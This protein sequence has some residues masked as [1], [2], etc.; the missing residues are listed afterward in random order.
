MGLRRNLTPDEA[1][2]RAAQRRYHRAHRLYWYSKSGRARFQTIP[3][4]ADCGDHDPAI[5]ITKGKG[6]HASTRCGNCWQR[7][8]Y[9][10]AEQVRAMQEAADLARWGEELLKL[11]PRLQNHDYL[12]AF[13][14]PSHMAMMK[15]FKVIVIL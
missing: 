5:L 3:P 12:E 7:K 11:P 14:T 15:R 6:R 10:R 8:K 2:F 13:H 1:A 9:L 4:C